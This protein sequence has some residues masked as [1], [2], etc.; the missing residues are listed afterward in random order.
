M[1]DW[2]SE[3][4]TDNAIVHHGVLE[5]GTSFIQKPFN[6]QDVAAKVQAVLRCYGPADNEP[7]L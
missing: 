6:I 3:D 5:G 2:C 7:D 4:V 1:G